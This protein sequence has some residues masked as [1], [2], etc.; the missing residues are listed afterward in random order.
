MKKTTIHL[1]RHGETEG[2]ASGRL[3]GQFD[4]PLTANGKGQ[5]REVGRI[6]SSEPFDCVYTSP[7]ERAAE[8]TQIICEG[9]DIDI[10]K[11]D[12]LQEISLGVWEGQ[13]IESI[14]KT[15]PGEFDDFLENPASF[16]LENA[17]T[18]HQLQERIVRAFRAITRKASSE[19]ILI[20]SHA[21]A[22][23][24]LLAH[25]EGRKL[26]NLWDPPKLDNCSHSIVESTDGAFSNITLFGGQ[27]EW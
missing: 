7:S 17:E 16:R 20:V 8:T 4:S 6:L 27:T 13:T 26:N 9:R 14:K 2:N 12:D 5:A 24:A 15:H 18:F 1:V 25:I 19:T 22:I 11:M 21:A 23:K 10:I 3:Q